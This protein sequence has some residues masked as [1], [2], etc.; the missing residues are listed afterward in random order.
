MHA[1]FNYNIKFNCFY[2]RKG[3]SNIDRLLHTL[4]EITSETTD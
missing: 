3:K 1:K 4:L 2:L